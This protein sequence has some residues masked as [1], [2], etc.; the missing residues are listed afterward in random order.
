MSIDDLKEIFEEEESM[1]IILL[2]PKELIINIYLGSD[3]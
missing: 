1:P 2:E 3:K